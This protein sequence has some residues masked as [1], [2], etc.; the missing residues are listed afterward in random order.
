VVVDPLRQFGD[1]VVRSV[2]TA[3][4]AEQHR[5]GDSIRFIADGYMLSEEQVTQAIEYES[6]R[7]RAPIAA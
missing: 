7:N 3:V 5:A 6:R 1:P 2:P 4:L